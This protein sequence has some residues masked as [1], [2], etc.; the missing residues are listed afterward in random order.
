MYSMV[1]S[2]Y[3][4]L[5]IGFS[6]FLLFFKQLNVVVLKLLYLMMVTI[7]TIPEHAWSATVPAVATILNIHTQPCS[8]LLKPGCLHFSAPWAQV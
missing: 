5:K 1:K 7:Q 2:F 8:Y 3:R 4:S 6:I